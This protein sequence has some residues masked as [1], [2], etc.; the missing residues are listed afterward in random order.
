MVFLF[1]FLTKHLEALEAVQ[2][3]ATLQRPVMVISTQSTLNMSV[4]VC[5]PIRTNSDDVVFG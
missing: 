2:H 5:G 3:L 4:W 1:L